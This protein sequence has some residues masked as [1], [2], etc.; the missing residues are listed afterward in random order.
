MIELSPALL[1]ALCATAQAMFLSFVLWR[2]RESH[3]GEA[4]LSALMLLFAI[5]LLFV[6]YY[7]A[8]L[9]RRWPEW[10]AADASTT[11]IYG[12][13]L[14]LFIRRY[15]DDKAL[16]R[17]QIVL[18]FLP[19]LI[20]QLLMMYVRWVNPDKIDFVA[21]LDRAQL[22]MNQQQDWTFNIVDVVLELQ[23]GAYLLACWLSYTRYKRRVY[24]E[25]AN[26]NRAQLKWLFSI[27]IGFDVLWT[28][29][30]IIDHT[31]Y[32]LGLAQEA[33]TLFFITMSVL[34]FYIGYQIWTHLPYQFQLPI[35]VDNREQTP[36]SNIDTEAQ[37][38]KYAKSALDTAA[39][40]QL[41]AHLNEHMQ[42]QQT[43]R[44]PELDL[45]RLAQALSL[46]AHYVSQVINSAAN[47]N[48][49]DYINQFRIEHIKSQLQDTQSVDKSILALAFDAGFNSKSAFYQAFKRHT[50]TTPSDYRKQFAK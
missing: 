39:V 37:N 7:Q 4:W 23:T 30:V 29:M 35:A 24:N 50:G 36:V 5:E 2:R 44:D 25:Q 40:T 19:A 34:V 8:N 11:L 6:L 21:E 20:S 22:Q 14:W 15:T 17:W 9:Y 16:P 38:E 42:T 48:F 12:P 10:I 46:P 26:T 49:Y 47:C 43:W 33:G 45:S 1:I 28:M 41:F 18:H 13:L 32:P 3:R 27:L 31:A